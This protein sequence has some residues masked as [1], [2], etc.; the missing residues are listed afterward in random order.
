MFDGAVVAE[1]RADSFEPIAIQDEE[2][3]SGIFDISIDYGPDGV[4]WIAYSEVE[5][6]KYVETH[7]ARSTD[8]GKTWQYVGILNKSVDGVLLHQGSRIEGVWR[9]ETPTLVFDATDVSARRWKL[10]VQKYFAAPPYKKGNSYF[11]RGQIEYSHAARPDGTWSTPMCLFGLLENGC[12]VDLNS[13]DPSLREMA[14]YNEIGSTVVA[15]TLYLSLDASAT[16]SGHGEW[17]KRK[18]ILIASDDHGEHWRYVGTLTDHDDAQQFGYVLLT[19]SSL[20]QEAGKTYLLVTPAGRKGLFVKN[21]GHDG[22]LVFA[23]DDITRARLRRDSN[24]KL[25]SLRNIRPT[26]QSG[27]LSDYHEKNTNGGI[28]FS[29]IDFKSAPTFF[30]VFNTHLRIEH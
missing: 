16:A 8:R 15:N 22:T 4:G 23:F 30:K 9:Y 12:R 1:R 2:R 20:V 21:R 26:L 13:L 25:V 11:G 3:S 19:G 18:I 27:G 6:P 10:F 28:L 14:F 5:L 29:Q 17:D 7:L 24:G